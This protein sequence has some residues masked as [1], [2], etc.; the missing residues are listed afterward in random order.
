MRAGG[1]TLVELICGLLVG[2]IVSAIALTAL[3][4]MAASVRV[5]R[6][7]TIDG[8]AARM[9]LAAIAR[10]LAANG[11]WRVCLYK[12]DCAAWVDRDIRATTIVATTHV[13]WTVDDGLRRC[14][15]RGDE[16]IGSALCD[17]YVP[18]IVALDATVD[19][20]RSNGRIARIPIATVMEAEWPDIIAIHLS[21]WMRHGRHHERSVR[22]PR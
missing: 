20:A 22:R 1:W 10:D 2:A 11:A 18:G 17:E 21:L 16:V 4:S 15:A 14:A 3:A 9:A 5:R 13:A 8:D 7:Q 19:V 12:R 6:T